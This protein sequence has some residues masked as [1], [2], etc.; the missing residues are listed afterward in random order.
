MA[1][2]QRPL[3]DYLRARL[4]A[5]VKGL[6]G[7]QE[8]K[9]VRLGVIQKEVSRLE[10]QERV[11]PPPSLL[12]R[13]FD[14]AGTSLLAVLAEYHGA[15]VPLT[16]DAADVAILWQKLPPRA[17]EASVELM[18]GYRRRGATRERDDEAQ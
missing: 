16:K 1:A 3:D 8:E 6:E 2:G 11:N 13:A 5:A 4:A 10:R 7:S 14:E 9:A 12:E 17:R 18:R 15:A